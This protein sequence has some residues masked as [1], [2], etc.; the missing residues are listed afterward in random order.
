MR[1][2]DNGR[3]L[4]VKDGG[5]GIPLLLL[6]G[7]P[8]SSEIFAVMRPLVER[9]GR[10]V[11][12]D[13]P[14]FGSSAA[15]A[16]GYTPE[17]GYTMDELADMV[18]RV[19]DHLGLERF[20]LGGHSMGGYVALRVA[21]RHRD[22]LSALVLIDTR[23]SAD[24]PEAAAKRHAAAVA[25]RGG[26]RAA[27]LDSFMP[28]LVGPTTLSRNPDLPGRLRSMADAVHDHVLAGCLEGMAARPD[29]RGLLSTLD[30][31]ALVVVGAEDQLTPVA[32]ARELSEALPRGRLKIIAEAGHTSPLECPVVFGDAVTV[33]LRELG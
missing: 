17:A 30:L 5:Q 11:T 6:H 14:G 31:P 15:P 27:F 4:E 33:F 13:L 26:G 2:T 23:A 19:A 18:V 21:A 25:I 9:V 28:L 22:R 10:V 1:V 7:F 20:A 24:S 32:E 8:L 3:S 12:L 29:S 16:A